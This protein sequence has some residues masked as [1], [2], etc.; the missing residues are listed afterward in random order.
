[1]FQFIY[2][3]YLL[4][5]NHGLVNIVLTVALD[6]NKTKPVFDTVTTT[7]NH[8]NISITEGNGTTEIRC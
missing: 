3:K 4:F 6:L 8:H 1:M 5:F 7:N 2:G